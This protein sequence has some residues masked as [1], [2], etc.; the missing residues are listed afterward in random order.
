MEQS[1]FDFASE[2]VVDFNIDL[3]NWPPSPDLMDA[4]NRRYSK[5]RQF[6]PER[7]GHGYLQIQLRAPVT[8]EFVTSAQR[9][10]SELA[11][12]FGGICESWG[13]MQE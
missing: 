11:R 4:L 10:M 12:P 6:P 7:D 5:I 1:G 9:E 8:Y 13:V 2:H 3:A